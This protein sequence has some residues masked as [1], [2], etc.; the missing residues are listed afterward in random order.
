[1]YQ[2]DRM[3][4]ALYDAK[5]KRF[6]DRSISRDMEN[7]YFDAE[8]MP[9]WR[10]HEH[11]IGGHRT[12]EDAELVWRFYEFARTEYRPDLPKLTIR[13]LLPRVRIED[14]GWL[15]ANLD[16]MFAMIQRMRVKHGSVMADALQKLKPDVQP[17]YAIKRKG[18]TQALVKEVL[19]DTILHEGMYMFFYDDH[20]IVLAKVALGGNIAYEY[21]LTV[22]H[23][24]IENPKPLRRRTVYR[25]RA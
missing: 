24:P 16:P 5:A 1:M 7:G 17:I 14:Q 18:K 11:L 6:L 20:D 12:A 9:L 4:Y 23:Q 10:E 22:F 15:R 21:D 19:P 8:W 3:F 25:N 2:I 13:K